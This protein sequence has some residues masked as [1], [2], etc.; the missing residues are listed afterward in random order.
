MPPGSRHAIPMT[1]TGVK[2][3]LSTVLHLS[4]P[5][6][7]FLSLLLALIRASRNLAEFF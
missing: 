5:T 1:A 2:P 6:H 4:L 7:K 3:A